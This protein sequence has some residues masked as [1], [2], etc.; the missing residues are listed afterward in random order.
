MKRWQAVIATL[1]CLP[2]TVMFQI[3]RIDGTIHDMTAQEL[4]D[5]LEN[6]S[7]SGAG[8]CLE[9]DGGAHDA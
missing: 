7:P 4:A 8:E 5:D 1:R 6:G 3:Q 2:E 9:I